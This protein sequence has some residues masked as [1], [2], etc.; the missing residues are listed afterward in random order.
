[1][2][3]A[4]WKIVTAL[5]A[6][7]V[8]GVVFAWVGP[9]ASVTPEPASAAPVLYNEET[10]TAIYNN[11]SPAVVEIT[12][13][14]IGIMGSF[15][16]GEGSGFLVDG[17]GNIL[18]NNH[19]VDG[20]SRVSV[21]FKNGTTVDAS[22]V[23]TDSVHDLALIHVEPS[24]IS[25]ITPLQ[26]GDSSTVKPGQMAIA[27]GAP[28]GLVDTITVGVISGLDRNISGSSLTGMLQT[29][30][31]LNPGNSGGPLLNADGEVIGIN[32]A[33]ET[34]SGARGIGFAV[35]SNVAKLALPN[36][37]A[38]KQVQRVWLGITGLALDADLAKQLDL[39][40]NQGVYVVNVVSG[41]PADKAGLKG[42]GSGSG[43]VPATGGDVI[44]TVDGNALK[45]VTD[46]TN[47][48]AGKQVGDQ[49]TLSIL[50]GGSTMSVTVTL[51]AWPSNLTTNQTP[52]PLPGIPWPWGG[53]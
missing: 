1:M 31:A 27:I 37:K 16:Q 24:T 45:S 11:A 42:S 35:P 39:P 9:L 28:Y 41:S 32:T 22:V 19:V 5:I 18:T 8:L 48:F 46:L 25:G 7:F 51:A 44:T 2:K 20:A 10:V 15:I 6:V 21:I 34:Q 33:V 52:S 53:R 29:D 26:L 40:V 43:G 30:A 12:V 23:G 50:R 3:K 38:G 36:L 4:N 14:G 17:D 13:Q 47:Y 49:V